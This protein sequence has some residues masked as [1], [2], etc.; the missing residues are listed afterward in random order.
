VVPAVAAATTVVTSLE[1]GFVG[2]TIVIIFKAIQEVVH[3]TV[4]LL[5]AELDHIREQIIHTQAAAVAAQVQQ[6][7]QVL[8]LHTTETAELVE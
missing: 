6:D 1:E 3:L 4:Q 5:L 8:I 7:S 2:T